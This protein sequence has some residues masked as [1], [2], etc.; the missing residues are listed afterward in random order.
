MNLSVQFHTD[1]LPV[2]YRLCVVSVIKECLRRG[3]EQAYLRYYD[4]H[5]PKPFVFSVYLDQFRYAGDEILLKGFTLNLSSSDY[6]FI[7]PFLNGLQ[8]THRF[9]YKEYQ[10]TRGLIRYGREQNVH[11]S[12][13]IVRTRS[14]LLV[15]DVNGIPL[16]PSDPTFCEE[17]HTIASR[18]SETLRGKP[19]IEKVRIDPVSYRKVVIKERNQPYEQAYEAGK[20][21]SPYLYFTAYH[22]TFHLQG[23]PA[24]L[25]WLLDTGG[26]LRNGQGFGHLELEREVIAGNEAKI[27]Y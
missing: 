4:G 27:A 17:F 8:Q 3:D 19:L 12:S 25:K 22:G 20:V 14:P 26:G 18:M 7:I 10:F 9:Q 11:S 15:E 5:K 16:A 23:H 6:D 24:D 2:A 1:K 13:I 21:Q